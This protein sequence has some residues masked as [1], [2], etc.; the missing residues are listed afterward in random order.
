MSLL[1]LMLGR[2]LASSEQD[3][4]KMGLAAGVPAMGLDGLSSAGYGTEA[5]MAL[6]VPLGAAGLA[7]IGPITLV[8]LVLLALLYLLL[9]SNH[10]G[11]SGERWVV[12]RR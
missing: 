6:L 11:L 12:H 9:P 3:E 5:A 1:T 4:G 8:V 10:R 7:Y 2:P